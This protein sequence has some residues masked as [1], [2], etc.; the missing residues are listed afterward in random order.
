MLTLED[1]INVNLIE[2]IMTERKITLPSLRNKDWKKVA[3]ETE[4]VN[5]LLPKNPKSNIIE[6]NKLIYSGVKLVC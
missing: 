4:N 6:V 2:K 5:K 1:K 3:I